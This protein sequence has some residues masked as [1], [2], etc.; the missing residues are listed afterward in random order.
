M[1]DLM[2]KKLR[3]IQDDLEV[4]YKKVETNPENY[5]NPEKLKQQLDEQMNRIQR[6]IDGWWFS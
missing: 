3:A 4:Q 1:N 5:E 6:E 2:K